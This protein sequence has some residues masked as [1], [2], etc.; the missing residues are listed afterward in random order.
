MIVGRYYAY[1][2]RSLSI[3][4]SGQLAGQTLGGNVRVTPGRLLPGDLLGERRG[5]C[6]WRTRWGRAP[7]AASGGPV[8]GA[9][10]VLPPGDTVGGAPRVLPPGDTVGERLG[11]C[12]RVIGR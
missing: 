6:F 1:R 4:L 10:R 12:L 5:G 7:G 3:R 11:S 8:G 2:L 9:P